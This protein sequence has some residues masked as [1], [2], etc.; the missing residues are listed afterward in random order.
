VIEPAWGGG[1]FRREQFQNRG[2]W[3]AFGLNP[4]LTETLVETIRQTVANPHM[5]NPVL[6]LRIPDERPHWQAL[7]GEVRAALAGTKEPTQ[8]LAAAAARW[9]ELDQRKELKVRLA[10]YRLSLGLRPKSGR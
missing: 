10:E 9:R 4:N 7:V 8:A 2:G 6:R 5:I 1:A 3:L